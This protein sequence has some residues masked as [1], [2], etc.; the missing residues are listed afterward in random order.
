MLKNLKLI[1]AV[2]C[3]CAT[4][5]YAQLKWQNVDSLYAPLPA[6]LHVFRS[7]DSLG[8]KPN[9]AFYVVADLNN[10]ALEF[11]TDTTYKRRLTPAGFYEKNSQPVVVVN[12]TFF[13]FQTNQN[14]NTVIRNRRP[15][16]YNVH[17]VP[18]RGKDTLTWKH[19]FTGAI[20]ITRRRKA[21]IAWIYSDSS[22]RKTFAFQMPVAAYKDSSARLSRKRAGSLYGR[23][24]PSLSRWKVSTA[25]GGGPVL[26]QNGNVSI[27]NNEEMKFAG[28]AINDKHPRTAMG[29]T[30]DGKLIILV[31]QGRMPGVSEG[32][33]L[34]QEATILKELGC[35]EALNLDG[36]GSSCLLV[37]GKETIKVSDKEG[38]RPVPAVFLI[39]AK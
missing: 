3:L 8:G 19:P 27:S 36:G 12:T 31:I 22:T 1:L 10:K 30:A 26:I 39:K 14:L 38:Q 15:L 21:D 35:Q 33:D 5:G 29:Y 37:N 28:K 9:I 17:A 23:N 24:V 32:A 25:V 20:G 7:S 16:A 18:G 11:T 4:N 6:G 34:N 13:S 2:S